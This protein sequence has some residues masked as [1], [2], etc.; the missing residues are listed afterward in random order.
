MTITNVRVVQLERPLE[1][2]QGNACGIRHQRRFTFVLV[3][4]DAGLT[5][6]GDAYG[7]QALM[8]P[9]LENR[10]AGMAAGL[11]PTNIEGVWQKLFASRSSWE[12][13][14]SFLCGISAI[15]VA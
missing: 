3:E 11:D 15:E 6:I 10:L 2:P 4:T 1:R 9:I 7:D 14:G 12:L 13:G 5:G 8:R